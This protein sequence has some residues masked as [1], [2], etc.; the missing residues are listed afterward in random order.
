[1]NVTSSS[2]T[3]ADLKDCKALATDFEVSLVNTSTVISSHRI[4]ISFKFIG[5]S[6]KHS[7]IPDITHHNIGLN[8]PSDPEGLK[9]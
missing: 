3:L 4:C 8:N 5:F 1:M 6:V 9:C 2:E 7:I